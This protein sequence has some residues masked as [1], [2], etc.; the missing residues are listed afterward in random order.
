MCCKAHL[1][2]R[3]HCIRRTH[4]TF[5]FTRDFVRTKDRMSLLKYEQ[6]SQLIYAQ[7]Y[8]TISMMK[9]QRFNQIYVK[10]FLKIR[11]T[12]PRFTLQ[13]WVRKTLLQRDSRHKNIFIC[14][15]IFLKVFFKHFYLL[16]KK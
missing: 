7:C 5:L 6:S 12:E 15:I 16:K 14:K 3:K 11:Y 2:T 13:L 9:S 10:K 1:Y 4:T 8:E